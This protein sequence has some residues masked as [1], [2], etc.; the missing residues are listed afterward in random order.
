MN[1]M[2]VSVTERTQEIGIRKSLGARKRDVLNQFIIE[3]ATV[4]GMGGTI[5]IIFGIA[6]VYAVGKI[7]KMQ[8]TPSILSIIISFS[9]SVMTGILFGYM[10]AKRAANLNPIDALRGE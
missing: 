2:L 7:A 3:A 1:I 10:P 9:V 6:L 8:A 4:S 5:G